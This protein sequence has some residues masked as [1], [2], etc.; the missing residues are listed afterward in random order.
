M[1]HAVQKDVGNNQL[2]IIFLSNKPPK[3]QVPD[4]V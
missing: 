4:I 3:S 2:V 1:F